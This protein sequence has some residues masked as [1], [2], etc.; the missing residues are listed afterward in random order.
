MSKTWPLSSKSPWS[1]WGD[2]QPKPKVRVS[3]EHKGTRAEGQLMGRH[4]NFAN[5]TVLKD[6]APAQ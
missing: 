6:E 4:R 3:G 2:S 5:V 1:S